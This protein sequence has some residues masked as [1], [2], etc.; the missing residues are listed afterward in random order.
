MSSMKDNRHEAFKGSFHTFFGREPALVEAIQAHASQRVLARLIDAD[1][2][3]FV[4]SFEPNWAEAEAFLYLAK[5]FRS[6]RLNVP[7]VI[8]VN[9]AQQVILMSDLGNQTLLDLLYHERMGESDVPETLERMYERALVDLTHFQHTAGHLVDFTRCYPTTAFTTA[10]MWQDCRSFVGA[11]IDMLAIP[12]NRGGLERELTQLIDSLSR[13]CSGDTFMYRDFQARNIVVKGRALGYI[14]FQ[15]G[16]RGPLAYDV[17]SLIYQAR[18]GLT[19]SVRARLVSAYCRAAAI[20]PGFNEG[21]FRER[22]DEWVVVR[23]LQ[24]LGR[25]GELGLQG[26]KELFRSSL[27]KGLSTLLGVLKSGHLSFKPTAL[28]GFVETLSVRLSA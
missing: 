14:D 9:R 12:G 19:P 3:S 27:P 17:A 28:L 20:I 2:T 4:G 7:D 22:F 26:K 15:G 6:H 11:I 13:D 8:A 10:D 25:A 16:R 24:A 21:A 23:L 1:G 5:H 18:A